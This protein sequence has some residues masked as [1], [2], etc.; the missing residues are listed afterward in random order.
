MTTR[1][2]FTS[3]DSEAWT[4]CH[5]LYSKVLQLK[6]SKSQKKADLI[7]LDKWFQEELPQT[8]SERTDKHITHEELAKLMRWKLMRGKFRPRLQ[9]LVESNKPEVVEETSRK[10][11]N[12]LPNISSAINEL[13]KLKAVGPATATAILA[14]AAPEL[15]PFMADESMLSI[16]GLGPVQYT[17][18]YFLKYLDHIKKCCKRLNKQD[19]EG[20][21]TPHKVELTLWTHAVATGLDPSVLDSTVADAADN[22]EPKSK[23]RKSSGE[24]EQ[25]AKRPKTGQEQEKTNGEAT[26]EPEAAYF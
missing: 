1:Q 23:K 10:A 8:L 3:G 14:A 21:W 22:A 16:P 9:Q 18:P 26:K 15:V 24:G 4:K 19:P 6:V 25:V 7:K 5:G 20:K 17:L 13:S 12:K 11:F 2:F